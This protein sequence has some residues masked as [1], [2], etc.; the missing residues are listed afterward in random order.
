MKQVPIGVSNRHI[1]VT[2]EDLEKLFGD[3]YELTL[4]K[5]LS[6]P[7]EFAAVETVIIK[8]EKSE[9]QKYVFS[10]QYVNLHKLRFLKQMHVILALMLQSVRLAILMELLG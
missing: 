4:A 1:H 10:D 6:Q 2:T 8:T 3:G 5:E 9:I 7:G